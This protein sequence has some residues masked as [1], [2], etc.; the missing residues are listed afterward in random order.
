M[1]VLLI[2]TH[3]VKRL[4]INRYKKLNDIDI[5]FNSGVNA[6]SGT[7]GTCKTTLLH[8]IS[9][10]YK[11]VS[12]TDHQF[13]NPEALRMIT[14]L[15]AQVNT[16][17]EKLAKGD[18]QYNNPAPGYKEG[19][20]FEVEYLDG[21]RLSFRRHNSSVN[22]RYA[23]KPYY[24]K[25]SHDRLPAKPVLYLGLA[26][27]IPWGEYQDD[28]AL[29]NS[30]FKLSEDVQSELSDLYAQITGIHANSFQAQNL[31]D[32]KKR[33]EFR[34]EVDGVDSNTVSSGEEN[35]LIL[36]TALLSL[37]HYYESLDEGS[38]SES[39]CSLLLVDELDA[40]LHPSF[41]YALLQLLIDYSRKFHIQIVFTTHSVF[42][43]RQMFKEKLNV[44]YLYDGAGVV[45][46]MDNPDI[47]KIE[48]YLTNKSRA[49]LFS[50]KKIPVFTEDEEARC[51]IRLLISHLS[52]I[53]FGFNHLNSHIHLIDGNLGGDVIAS[54]FNDVQLRQSAIAS[55]AILDGDKSSNLSNNIIA[56]PGNGLSPEW[57]VFD[58][59]IKIATEGDNPFWAE[60]CIQAEGFSISHFNQWIKP[61]IDTART[62]ADGKKKREKAKAIFNKNKLFFTYIFK[63]WML[64][65]ENTEA[66]RIFGFNLQAVYHK[67]ANYHRIFIPSTVDFGIYTS[68]YE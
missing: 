45:S 31:R 29:K 49:D 21:S 68:K 8:M 35:V 61:D 16:K 24:K 57:L 58:Y 23:I 62:N 46:K 19:S 25:G 32:I 60:D 3:M 27:L 5:E 34:T 59:A 22:N 7:N 42:L 43:L 38:R 10:A 50:E 64:D 18:K 66:I 33:Q 47:E 56:L 12:K 48:M 17:I 63:A 41:Q 52:N 44:I 14:S 67:T 53:A 13:S 37:K 11:A 39:V 55:F 65:P 30:P 51:L 40:T 4:N 1:T 28:S 36:L 6:I 9:N 26:R 20:L 54:L 2:G 15:N